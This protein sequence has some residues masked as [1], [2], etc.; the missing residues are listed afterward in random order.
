MSYNLNVIQELINEA[1]TSEEFDD[2]VKNSFPNIQRQFT[3]EQTKFQ[4]IQILIDYVNTHGEIDK[5]LESIKSI[6]QKVY[7]EYAPKL[8]ID[9][10]LVT[11]EKFEGPP[12][13]AIPPEELLI[14]GSA[15]PAK[16]T[17]YPLWFG[18]NRKAV[19]RQDISKGFSGERDNKLNYGICKVA[20]PKSHKI[21]STGSPWWKRLLTLT[22]DR[23][24]LQSET[25]QIL[26]EA[27]FWANMNQELQEHEIDERSALVFIHG[28]NVSFE[29]AALRAAQIGFDLQVPGIMAFYSWPSQ[30]KLTDYTVDEATIQAS[31]KYIAEFLLNLAQKSEIEKIHIIAHSMG[32]R[33]LLRAMQRIV[34]QVQTA[35]SDNDIAFGQ[36]FLAA[37]D[38]DTDLFKDLAS[39]YHQLAERTTLYVSSKDKALKASAIIHEHTRVGFFPPITVVEGIDTVEVSNIDVTL[40]GHGYFA[41]ALTLL[42]DIKDLLINNTSPQQRQSIS[43][44]SQD[45][46][47]WIMGIGK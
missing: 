47:Y 40:L 4:K 38:V 15:A 22:D 11:P 10:N 26:D 42:E 44:P 14:A 41:E 39:A 43:K 1:L 6:N 16:G 46:N 45:G 21:G 20:V 27:M 18:T 3:N 28:F 25:L 13:M 32:N 17:L 12:S 34:A 24:K 7:E 5:L 33:G 8:L 31:E 35:S 9:D 29:D 36:I 19:D 2:L 37:P 23:L 30:G